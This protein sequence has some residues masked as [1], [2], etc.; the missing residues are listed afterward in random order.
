MTL[1]AGVKKSNLMSF[2][3]FYIH[4]Y[5]AI[6]QSLAGE[7][8]QNV[9]GWGQYAGGQ[10]LC[11]WWAGAVL[12]RSCIVSGRGLYCSEIDIMAFRV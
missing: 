10:G 2:W 6:K 7:Q 9:H 12:G 1:K 4:C 11:C 3:R 8:G 5:T